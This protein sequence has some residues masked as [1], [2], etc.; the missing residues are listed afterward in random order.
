ML[1]AHAWNDFRDLLKAA[2]L[3]ELELGTIWGIE[4]VAFQALAFQEF[5][6]DRDLVGIAIKA[7]TPDGDKV[8]RARA[9]QFRAKA[10]M[11]YLVEGAWVQPFIIEALDFPNGRHDDQVDTASGGLQM[12]AGESGWAA[13]AKRKLEEAIAKAKAEQEQEQINHA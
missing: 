1:R 12:M 2:M 5:M 7:V 6:A 4:D 8:R 11:V 10:G 13:W 9:L 3:S